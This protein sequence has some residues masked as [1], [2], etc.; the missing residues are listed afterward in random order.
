MFLVSVHSK[1]CPA[2]R[3]LCVSVCVRA[4]DLNVIGFGKLKLS[5]HSITVLL[6]MKSSVLNLNHKLDSENRLCE[7]RDYFK[8]LRDAYRWVLAD[9]ALCLWNSKFLFRPLVT[10][11]DM[12]FHVK[13]MNRIY[14][15]PSFVILTRKPRENRL[16]KP[17]CTINYRIIIKFV[18][19]EDGARVWLRSGFSGRLL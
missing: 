5:E 16:G 15:Q 7:L 2:N 3:G 4:C 17:K 6:C 19:K 10:A 14:F 9:S 18:L 1:V 13:I 11:K 8:T 12:E